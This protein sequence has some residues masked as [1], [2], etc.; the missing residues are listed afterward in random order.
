M[1]L[2]QRKCLFEDEKKLKVNDE[3]SYLSCLNDCRVQNIIKLCQCIP[4]FYIHLGQC[5]SIL[6]AKFRETSNVNQFCAFSALPEF[7]MIAQCS[8]QHLPC[9][10]RIRSK[11]ASFEPPGEAIGFHEIINKSE[12][13]LKCDECMPGCRETVGT[14][15]SEIK[16]HLNEIFFSPIIQRYGFQSIL[17]N[18]RISPKES[19]FNLNFNS[20]A[21]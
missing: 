11:I 12:I 4:Y 6:F 17:S 2:N 9:L 21:L 5:F 10:Y 16:F 13:G 8:F 7:S 14:H 20:N 15:L 1:P 3:Y 18:R 19:E